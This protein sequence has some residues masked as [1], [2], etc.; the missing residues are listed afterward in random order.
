MGVVG[1]GTLSGWLIS[2]MELG[3][4]VRMRGMECGGFITGFP[5]VIRL[6]IGLGFVRSDILSIIVPTRMVGLLV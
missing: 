2:K 5:L 6:E 3:D 4:G 1:L